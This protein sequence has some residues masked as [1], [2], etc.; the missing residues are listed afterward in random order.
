MSYLFWVDWR[1]PRLLLR[2][3]L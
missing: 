3:G 1:L 2:K